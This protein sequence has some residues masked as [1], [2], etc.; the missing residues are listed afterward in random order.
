MSGRTCKPYCVLH[1]YKQTA[2]TKDIMT[3]GGMLLHVSA[4]QVSVIIR[5]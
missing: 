5:I 1:R 3:A 2:M 4:H